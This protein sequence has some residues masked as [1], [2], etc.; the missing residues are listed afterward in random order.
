MIHDIIPTNKRLHQIKIAPTDRCNECGR[1]DT[2]CDH[3]NECGDS[4]ETWTQTKIIIARMLRA[5]P[6]QI[7]EDWLLRPSVCIWPPQRH[8]AVLWVLS[9]YVYFRTHY[10][11]S[12]TANELMDFYRRSRWKLYLTSSKRNQV[13]N[14]LTVLDGT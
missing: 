12:L 13:A 2:L 1:K 10:Q 6:V 7:P 8:R 5:S 11:P 14:Y 3:L 4:Q 9:R